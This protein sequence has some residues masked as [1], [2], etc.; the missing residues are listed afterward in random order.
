MFDYESNQV[1]VSLG[2]LLYID[3]LIEMIKFVLHQ[4]LPPLLLSWQWHL[5]HKFDLSLIELSSRPYHLKRR[6]ESFNLDDPSQSPYSY[7]P[8]VS[9]N[10]LY[11]LTALCPLLLLYLQCL[12]LHLLQL[13][14]LILQFHPHPCINI[15]LCLLSRDYCELLELGDIALLDDRMIS[16]PVKSLPLH[17]IPRLQYPSLNRIQ[18]L[19]GS[20]NC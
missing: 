10:L 9:V 6:H 11:P 2:R 12:L 20:V 15:S 4:P 19:L 16:P 3:L 14:Q 8:V 13:F 7:P 17:G 18:D 5:S 1:S